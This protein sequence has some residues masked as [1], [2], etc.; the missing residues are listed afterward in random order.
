MSKSP[1]LKYQ[2]N[3]Q[4]SN[5]SQLNRIVSREVY[6]KLNRSRKYSDT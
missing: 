5:I 6:Y 1:R 2:S 3:L 4:Q